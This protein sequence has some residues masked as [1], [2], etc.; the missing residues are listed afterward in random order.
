MI[1]G[2]KKAIFLKRI[3]SFFRLL[4]ARLLYT[5]TGFDLGADAGLA[6]GLGGRE[7]GHAEG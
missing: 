5:G 3:D 4:F 6:L 1:D 2:T 7:G